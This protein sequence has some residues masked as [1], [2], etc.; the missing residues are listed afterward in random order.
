VEHCGENTRLAS[1]EEALLEAALAE[2]E[3]D[4]F[5]RGQDLIRRSAEREG[6]FPTTPVHCFFNYAMGSR[7]Q[8]TFMTKCLILA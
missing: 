2:Y 8:L 6:Y 1:V 5:V 7:G 3:N 4:M